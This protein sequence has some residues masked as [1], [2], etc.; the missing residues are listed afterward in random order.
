MLL[1]LI[2]HSAYS[3]CIAGSLYYAGDLS[4]NFEY[5][6]ETYEAKPDHSSAGDEYCH[7][8]LEEDVYPLVQYGEEFY[9]QGPDEPP[10]VQ[11]ELCIKQMPDVRFKEACIALASGRKNGKMAVE[12]YPVNEAR[13]RK[14]WNEVRYGY[15]RTL[16][17]LMIVNHKT[18]T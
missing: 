9:I 16:P 15:N 13:L 17:Y 4:T 7:P 6:C 5:L 10:G 8:L 12:L 18:L 2:R 14:F 11:S 3:D 1:K